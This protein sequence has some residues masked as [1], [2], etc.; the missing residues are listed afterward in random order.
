[1]VYSEKLLGH[2]DK[3]LEAEIATA[4]L[5]LLVNVIPERPTFVVTRA[6]SQGFAYG[7]VD[8]FDIG[9]FRQQYYP[10]GNCTDGC[11]D[12][13][14]LHSANSCASCPSCRAAS[15]GARDSR[16]ASWGAQTESRSST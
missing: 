16:G 2:L 9:F 7:L 4:A 6:S 10:I 15:A 8:L 11:P 14:S 3:I 13:R 5:L 1:M 12:G